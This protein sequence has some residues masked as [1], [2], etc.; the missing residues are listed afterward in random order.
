MDQK[1]SDMAPKTERER[2]RAS[3]YDMACQAWMELRA[4]VIV[5]VRVRTSGFN[6]AA[7]TIEHPGFWG[8]LRTNVRLDPS[9]VTSCV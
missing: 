3:R 2:P 8:R 9:R 5:R 4:R 1:K 6:Q 7:F